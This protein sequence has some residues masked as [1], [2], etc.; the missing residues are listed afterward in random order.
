MTDFSRDPGAVLRTNLD[1]GF[2][3][4]HFQQG[5]PILDRDLNLLQ[6]LV[7]STVRSVVTRY[8]GS[9]VPQ[10]S[11]AFRI[12]ASDRD[13]DVTVLAGS[14]LPGVCMVDG[15]EVT[16][17]ANRR[18]TDQ[19]GIDPGAWRPP[20]AASRTDTVFLDVSLETVEDDA[21]LEND[22]IGIA[23]TVRLRPT[24]TARVAQGAAPP[25]PDP[26]H[27]HFE[28]ARVTRTAGT[29]RIPE[30]AIVDVRRQLLTLPSLG[31]L[32]LRPRI[33]KLS[34]TTLGIGGSLGIDG[35]GFH[36]ENLA[37]TIGGRPVDGQVLASPNRID[38]RVPAGVAQGPTQLVVSTVFGSDTR[39]FT[40][41]GV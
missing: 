9:G 4:L 18:Y 28:L 2:V 12:G 6:D 38:C 32:V 14:G 26:G 7:A 41:A 22:D 15:I 1:Q 19:T 39:A 24:W 16:I 31:E 29:N 25:G 36:F 27:A 34:V 17:R 5:V 37:V 8:L 20:V 40:V 3:G 11:G 35:T 23:T 13:H 21:V 30:G 33:V 10:S